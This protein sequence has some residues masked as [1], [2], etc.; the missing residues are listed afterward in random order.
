M[1]LGSCSCEVRTRA[2]REAHTGIVTSCRER[3]DMA[4][5]I[6]YKKLKPMRVT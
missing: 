3:L 4:M 5:L 2:Q 1:E 6:V